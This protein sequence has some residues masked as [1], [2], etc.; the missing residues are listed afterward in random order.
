MSLKFYF[1]EFEHWFSDKFGPPSPVELGR[2]KR[3]ALPMKFHADDG[4]YTWEDWE[5]EVK[6]DYPVRYFIGKTVPRQLHRKIINPVDNFFYWLRTNTINK[7]HL[8]DL[9]QPKT[10]TKDDYKWGWIDECDKLILANFS[11]LRD[12]MKDYHANKS[13]VY[14]PDEESIRLLE[15]EL[16]DSENKSGSKDIGIREQI[17]HL[18]EIKNIWEYWIFDRKI[19]LK[20]IDKALKNW[21]ETPKGTIKEK[22]YDILKQLEEDFD[23]L[24]EDMLIRLIRVRKSLWI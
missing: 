10:D 21:A 4:D 7:Y 17:K 24:E 2:S 13:F 6:K 9:R 3:N 19:L 1:R 14:G 20:N 5:I 8:L 15:K 23:I 12:Y 22:R 16:I 18:K 11:V